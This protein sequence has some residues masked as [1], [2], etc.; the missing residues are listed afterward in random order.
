MCSDNKL[1]SMP[2]FLVKSKEMNDTLPVQIEDT[3]DQQSAPSSREP[4]PMQSSVDSINAIKMKL[5]PTQ[6]FK[7][8]TC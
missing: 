5:Y 1:K 6:P 7:I 3:L 4:D 8:L 2:D